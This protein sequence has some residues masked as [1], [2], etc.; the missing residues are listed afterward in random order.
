MGNNIYA[1]YT[2]RLRDYNNYTTQGIKTRLVTADVKLAYL[3]SIWNTELT[4]GITFHK[5]SST[6]GTVMGNYIYIGIKTLLFNDY[7]DF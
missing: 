2:T 3:L 4:A 1:S 7:R 6:L 5:Q